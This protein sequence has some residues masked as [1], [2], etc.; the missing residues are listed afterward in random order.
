MLNTHKNK[1]LNDIRRASCFYQLKTLT[2]KVRFVSERSEKN[3]Y[4]THIGGKCLRIKRNRKSKCVK[5]KIFKK[6]I[7]IILHYS[8]SDDLW[9]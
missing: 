5:I 2:S 1:F 8:F 6:W 7:V 4:Y 9:N 3:K